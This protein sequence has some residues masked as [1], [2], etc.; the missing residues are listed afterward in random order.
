MREKGIEEYN[1]YLKKSAKKEENDSPK[2][3]KSE[4]KKIIAYRLECNGECELAAF[5]KRISEGIEAPKARFLDF[6]KI[7]ENPNSYGAGQ[8]ACFDPKLGIVLYDSVNIPTEFMTICMDCNIIQT[9]PGKIDIDLGKQIG[10]GLSKEARKQSRK[11]FK[12]WGINYDDTN[13]IFD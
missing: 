6:I 3:S 9:E 4:F 1:N 2:F 7:L 13:Q 11:I 10:H 5:N 8:A 12:S